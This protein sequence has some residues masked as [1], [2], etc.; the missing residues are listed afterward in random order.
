MSNIVYVGGQ[1]GGTTKTTTSHLMCL[2]AILRKQPAAYVLTDPHRRIKA[3]R[4]GRMA[5]W[6]AGTAPD[7][8]RSLPRATTWGTAG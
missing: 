3:E 7:W 6:T 4:G 8:R 2:G 5:S 1:K